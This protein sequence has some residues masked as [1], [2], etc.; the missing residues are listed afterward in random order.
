MQECQLLRGQ[1][2]KENE[3]LEAHCDAVWKSYDSLIAPMWELSEDQMPIH[4]TLSEILFRLEAM[5]KASIAEMDSKSRLVELENM[6]DSLMKLEMETGKSTGNEKGREICKHLLQQCTHFLH[7]LIHEGKY[8]KFSNAYIVD[9]SLMPIF[10]RLNDLVDRL[11]RLRDSFGSHNFD[12]KLL[13][14]LQSEAIEI[15]SYR[16]D[17]TFRDL[18]G[19]IPKG[20]AILVECLE[21]AHD[22]IHE[23][24]I[25]QETACGS[26]DDYSTSAVIRKSLKSWVQMSETGNSNHV[27]FKGLSYLQKTFMIQLYIL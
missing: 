27:I 10:I 18:K 12:I 3:E 5:K 2:K 17:G 1:R 24:I 14:K 7:Q 26:N 25:L 15:E 8:I 22:L 11:H 20:Q 23:C 6:K 21:T 9:P 13:S 4:D 19:G 16:I